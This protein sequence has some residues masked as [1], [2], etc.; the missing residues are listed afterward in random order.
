MPIAQ[1]NRE[2]QDL[3]TELK[4][5]N[6]SS[7]RTTKGHWQ[8]KSPDGKGLVTAGGSYGDWRAIRNL[9]TQLRKAGF[10]V[11]ERMRR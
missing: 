8:F 5:Q 3:L 4:I 10:Q 1:K 2:F 7:T 9:I 11:P 6:W